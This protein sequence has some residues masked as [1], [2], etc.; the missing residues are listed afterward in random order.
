MIGFTYKKSPVASLHYTIY[1]DSVG[2]TTVCILFMAISA[3]VYQMSK[4]Y[5]ASQSEVLSFSLTLANAAQ[6]ADDL[7]AVSGQLNHVNT[8]PKTQLL[9]A[10][11]EA[12]TNSLLIALTRL[13]NADS[14]SLGTLSGKRHALKILAQQLLNGYRQN[15]TLR[16]V[17]I[18]QPNVVLQ[19]ISE[20]LSHLS[21]TVPMHAQQKLH[22]IKSQHY[23]WLHQ[24]LTAFLSCF[25][26]AII[27][28]ILYQRKLGDSIDS[29][30]SNCVEPSQSRKLKL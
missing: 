3:V 2:M 25:C 11:F 12:K 8:T 15:G 14:G 6:N 18:N 23:Q 21:S 20:D 24:L 22:A 26:A 1:I 9:L 5:I 13:E 4:P 10:Q 7:G 27:C 29:Q 30:H 16:E 19:S 17:E 28:W